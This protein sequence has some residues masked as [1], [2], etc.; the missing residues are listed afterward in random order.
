MGEIEDVLLWNRTK[1]GE[2]WYWKNKPRRHPKTGKEMHQ[3]CG[4]LPIA[5]HG[6]KDAQWF[7]KL[8]DEFYGFDEGLLVDNDWKRYRW[9]NSLKTQQYFYRVRKA[10]KVALL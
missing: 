4:V 10:M 2:W 3:C 9:R 7:Y 6:Y 5:F 1:Q 8:E